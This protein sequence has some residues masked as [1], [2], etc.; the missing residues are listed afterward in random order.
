M[1]NRAGVVGGIKI[2]ADKI[3]IKILKTKVHAPNL[4]K[5]Q[6][7]GASEKWA[8]SSFMRSQFF[9]RRWRP[10]APLRA[11]KVFKREYGSKGGD[12]AGGFESIGASAHNALM[13]RSFLMAVSNLPI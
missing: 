1:P 6:L 11:M 5:E 8:S 4:D 2:P 9:R 7:Q 13:H 10:G 12:E 3:M